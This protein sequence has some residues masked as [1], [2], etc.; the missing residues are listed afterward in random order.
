M[1]RLDAWL[2][3]MLHQ[4]DEYLRLV[5]SCDTDKAED[6]AATK[7]HSVAEEA[8][9]YDAAVLAAKQEYLLLSEQGLCQPD[10]QGCITLPSGL[11]WKMSLSEAELDA[12]MEPDISL[13]KWRYV[14]ELGVG[15]Q[16]LVEAGQCW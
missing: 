4:R 13:R 12:E 16:A 1:E 10:S 7:A 3:D 11:R 9:A 5:S 14:L 15:Q 6:G 8:S 2:L